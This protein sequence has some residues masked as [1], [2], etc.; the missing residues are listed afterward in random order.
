MRRPKS[1]HTSLA[2]YV[3]I[4]GVTLLIRCGNKPNADPRLRRCVLSSVESHVVVKDGIK[5]LVC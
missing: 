5:C 2:L 3:L 4:R 1:R